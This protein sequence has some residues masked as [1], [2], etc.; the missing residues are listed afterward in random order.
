[1]PADKPPTPRPVVSRP[2]LLVLAGINGA[3]KSSVAGTSLRASGMD[4][5][6]PD[7][8]TDRLR[9]AGIEDRDAN[10][11]AWLHGRQ[12]LEAAIANG[13]PFAFE[14]TLGGNTMSMLIAKAAA[15]HDVILWFVGLDSA[16]RHLARVAARVTA[17]G[18]DIPTAKI[19][20]RWGSARRNLIALMPHLYELRAYDN[21]VEQINADDAEPALLL[22][23]REGRII[24]PAERTLRNT[25]DWAKAIVEAARCGLKERSGPNQTL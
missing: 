5:Y 17:G 20:E 24:A 11:A 3:G 7:E 19:H 15:T 18:H 8:A 21:S 12:A 22:H 10:A 23:L 6:N 16:E 1:M 14:T 9:D 4:Y 2:T 25:P 13:T